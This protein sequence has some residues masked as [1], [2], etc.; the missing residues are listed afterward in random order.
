MQGNHPPNRPFDDRAAL[1][2]LERL[3]IAIREYRRQREKA[4]GEF[5]AFVGS[6]RTSA[7]PVGVNLNPPTS[8]DPAPMG[9]LPPQAVQSQSTG[10]S[11]ESFE[12]ALTEDALPPRVPFD[13]FPTDPP[14]LPGRPDVFAD[15]PAPKRPERLAVPA[16]F[17]G[18]TPAPTRSRLPLILAVATL[19][20]VAAVVAS[21]YRPVAAP[22]LTSDVAAPAESLPAAPPEESSAGAPSNAAPAAVSPG[23]SAAPTSPSGAASPAPAGGAPSAQSAAPFA[24]IRTVRPAWVRVIVDGRRE[25]ERELPADSRIPLPAGTTFVVRAGDAGAVHFFL[26]GQDQG[27]LGA[28]AQVVTRTFTAPAR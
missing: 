27:P 16:D 21:R 18:P 23:G 22:G 7:E 1:E 15:E 20:L 14:T 12:W 6:F 2:E 8:P 4:E 28:N 26:K 9:P 11:P 17:F 5:D 24:E 3:Q 13:R 25:M 10:T 19:L